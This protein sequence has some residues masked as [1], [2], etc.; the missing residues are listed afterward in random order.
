M[1]MM[2]AARFGAQGVG[3]RSASSPSVD[4]L[5]RVYAKC[6][7]GQHDAVRRRVERGVRDRGS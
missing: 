5:L 6:I 4:F 7:A 3:S 2:W 1:A